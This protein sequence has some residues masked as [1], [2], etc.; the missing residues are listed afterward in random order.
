MIS[1][2]LNK[3]GVSVCKNPGNWYEKKLIFNNKFIQVHQS[4]MQLSELL[5]NITVLPA[6]ADRPISHISL[7]SRKISKQ[8]VFIAVKGTQQ[9]GKKFISDAIAHHAAAIL[10]EADATEHAIA[11][12]SGVLLIPIDKL[13]QKVAEI[14][15][16]FYHHPTKKLRTIGITGTNGKTSCTHFLA[17]LLTTQNIPCGIIGTLGNGFY[18]AL[19][20]VGLTT[21]DPITLQATLADFAKQGAQ[22]VAMEVSSHSIAQA[23]IGAIDFEI[24]TFTNLS[25]D[26]LDYHG[27]ME[28]YA[29]VKRQFLADF[30]HKHVVINADDVWGRQWINELSKTT[31]VYAFSTHKPSNCPAI[32]MVYADKTNFTLEGIT[33]TVHSPWGSE[34]IMLPLIGEFNLSNALAVLTSLCLYGVSFDAAIAALRSL[35]AVPGRVQ[36]LGGHEQP[37]VVVDYAHSP[38]A[39]DKVL[40]TLRKHTRGKLICVFG[41][42]GERDQG[43]RPLMAKVAEQWADR[44]IVTNDNPRKEDPQTIVKQIISGFTKP[45]QV[46]VILD[47]SK[48][49]ENSIQWASVGD[50][51]LIAGKGAEH[52]Q[53]IGDQK[54]PFDDVSEVRKCLERKCLE[55]LNATV[56]K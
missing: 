8:D 15:A 19:G 13:P 2:F 47:R 11:S 6:H 31:S 21:P 1:Q 49:I 16:Q 35:Q 50:C 23:R 45:D 30:P 48:A 22:A 43:K 55:N 56:D 28:A 29:A 37:T 5:K 32:P 38:D 51:V 3:C 20:P 4:M 9:D 54:I 33:A 7:D 39:L 27:T 42:G 12:Q 10:V 53:Q 24:A 17:Q 52:Y 46:Q 44:V 14:A 25:Q 18:N 40:Q 41:C 26:H 36:S 34:S